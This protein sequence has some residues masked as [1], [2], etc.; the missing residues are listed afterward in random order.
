MR[1]WF[2]HISWYFKQLLPLT[3][4]TEYKEDGVPYVSVWKMWIGRCYKHRKYQIV[5]RV[6]P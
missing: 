5:K 2:A 3:Y 6:S 4:V 1:E